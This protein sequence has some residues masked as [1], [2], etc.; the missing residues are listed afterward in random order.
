MKETILEA[1]KQLNNRE[2]AVGVWLL[3][4][5]IAMLWSISLRRGLIDVLKSLLSPKLI[6]LFGSFAVYVAFL[7][8][9]LSL[10]GLWTFDQL[11]ATVLWYFL[12]GVGLLS[13]VFSITEGD[14]H[15]RKLFRGAF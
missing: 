7:V 6:L 10:V 9:L 1:L 13:G 11:T 12:S 15:F 14:Q 3:V 5:L 8:W 4:S 2:I